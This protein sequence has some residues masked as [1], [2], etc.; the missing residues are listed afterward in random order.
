MSKKK[1]S[2]RKKLQFSLTRFLLAWGL[3]TFLWGSVGLA[4]GLIYYS[5]DLPS[6]EGLEKITAQPAIKVYDRDGAMIA[7]YGRLYGEKVTYDDFPQVLVDAIT[8][9]EDRR[10]FKHMG[11]D[12]I[13]LIRAAYVNYRAGEIVQGGSTITQQLAKVTF[14]SSDRTIKRKIQEVLLA[15][16]LEKRFSKEEILTMYLNRIYFGAGNYGVS[17]A[18][19]F[20][21]DKDVAQLDL[22][23]SAMIAGLIKAP[24][25]YAP[26]NNPELAIKRANLVLGAMAD[27]DR[28]PEKYASKHQYDL[29][30][31]KNKIKRKGQYPYFAQWIKEQLPDYMGGIQRD[32]TVRTSFD[33]RLQRIAEDELVQGVLRDSESHHVTQGAMVVLSKDGAVL[34]MVGGLDHAT[35]QFNRVT[36]ALRQPG[37]SFK[38]LVYLTALERG[39]SPYDT[40]RDEQ[41]TIGGWTPGNWN[42]RYV[43]DVTLRNALTHS[44]NTVAVKLAQQVGINNVVETG[45]RL[46]ITTPLQANLSTALGASE[47]TLMEL[48]AAYGHLAN[49]GHAVWVHGIES[50]T[51]QDGEVIYER[52]GSETPEVIKPAVV[53]QMNDMLTEVI[54]SG[55]GKKARIDRMAAGKTGTSQNYRDAWFV[56]YT[57][58]YVVGIW[59]GND[60]NSPTKQVNGG[61]LPAEIWHNFMVRANQGVARKNLYMDTPTIEA[62]KEHQ[63]GFWSMWK[64]IFDGGGN[65]KDSTPD[66]APSEAPKMIQEQPKPRIEE[67]NGVKIEYHYPN[68]R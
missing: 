64:N 50:I 30:I 46:G 14:L 57:A 23:E 67:K 2:N 5:R 12:P 35:S 7:H 24:S 20:Y 25:R 40:V 9:I 6:V 63:G 41:I 65:T 61:N 27:E 34:A 1:N 54:A 19:R 32:L 51:D 55:T 60:D 13:G 3:A 31:D 58:D 68:Q 52:S 45:Y 48:T 33:S 26:T 36:Q 56:G 42:N 11:I 53:A 39:F 10:F 16:Y 47:V 59:V 44:I 62:R 38:L 29:S 8:S 66:I 18:A 22:Y 4:F 17:A 49:N 15:L 28:I 43:G 21:F 37:S